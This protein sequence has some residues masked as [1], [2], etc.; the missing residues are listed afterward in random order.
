GEVDLIEKDPLCH[1]DFVDAGGCLA[2][3]QFPGL[4]RVGRGGPSLQEGVYLGLDTSGTQ[5]PRYPGEGY[6]SDRLAE[7]FERDCDDAA[8]Y[9]GVRA[10]VHAVVPVV[11]GD[12][13][14]KVRCEVGVVPDVAHYW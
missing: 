10:D 6:A 7:R 3:C 12:E 13:P 4:Y 5:F 11:P 1:S 2:T 8:G 9:S 14:K